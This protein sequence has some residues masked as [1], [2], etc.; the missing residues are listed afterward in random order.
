[1]T[2]PTVNTITERW[3]RANGGVERR[4]T[5]REQVL[6]P[7]LIVEANGRR[8]PCVILDRSEGGLRISLPTEEATPELFCILDL[9]TG[10]GREVEVAWR[11]GPQ[12]GLR[13]MQAY[14]LDQPQQGVGEA[15]R[16][17][18]IAVLG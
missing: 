1:M 8:R 18:R 7:A 10:M 11:A 13:I 12:M 9:V 3:S 14:D 6:L 5:P 15:L 16:Q 2:V 17:I 4:A